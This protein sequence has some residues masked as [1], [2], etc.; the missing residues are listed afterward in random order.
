MVNAITEAP[1]PARKRR[2]VMGAAICSS[3]RMLSECSHVRSLW[4]SRN[5]SE[6][7]RIQPRRRALSNPG[8]SLLF[9]FPY[10]LP[11]GRVSS[12]LRLN[13]NQ[14][15][16]ESTAITPG[17][18][19]LH[20][21]GIEILFG[22]PASLV[23]LSRHPLAAAIS[24]VPD[25]VTPAIADR[26]DFQM[27][28]R[29]HLT[30]WVGMRIDANEANRLVKL[31]PARLLE[32]YRK[33]P[34]RQS[35]DGEHVGK[36]LH[37]ATLAWVNTGDPALRQKTRLRGRRTDQVPARRRLPG[38]LPREGPLDRMGCVGA[39]IQP[40]R[41]DHLHALHRQPGAAAGLPPHG[42]PALQ[43][44]WRSNPASATS[45]RPG[46]TWA[47]RPPACWSR[48]CCSTA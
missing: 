30:G 11:S 3:I 39:Q 24:P 33:R 21:S 17:A 12:A 15:S 29:V 18:S 43:H 14:H 32:G 46:S 35:W 2:R 1:V 28:D 44:L 23:A 42:R 47:W 27:P 6:F 20:S 45:S 22:H 31:D 37:A 48:W 10:P 25:K 13:L 5:S 8:L 4:L 36:W 16:Y 38:H 19:A 26:Q 7:E 41:P 9:A 40:H 34:G